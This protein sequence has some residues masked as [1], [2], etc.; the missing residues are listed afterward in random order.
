MGDFTIEAVPAGEY[1]IRVEHAGFRTIEQ[2]VAVASGAAPVL[3]FPMQ[4]STLEEKVEVSAAAPAVSSESSTTQSV[5]ARAEI[6]RAPGASR[7]NS[8]AMITDFVPGAYIVH[9]Q[10]H[11]RGGTRSPGRWIAFRFP[12]PTSQLRSGRNLIPRTSK[13]WKCSGAGMQPS[14]ATVLLA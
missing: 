13:P 14:T 4:L 1:T 10:L 7:T 5:V 8:L 11:I 12:T 6:D 9:D 2:T 3:H